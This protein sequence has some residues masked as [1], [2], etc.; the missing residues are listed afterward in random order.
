LFNTILAKVRSQGN[1]ALAV[2]SSGIAALLLDDGRTA[3]S[4]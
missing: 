1:I 2:A 4:I 3:H